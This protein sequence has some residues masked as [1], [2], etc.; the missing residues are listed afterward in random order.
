MYQMLDLTGNSTKFRACFIKLKTVRCID[1][2]CNMFSGWNYFVE[3]HI[4]MF[5]TRQTRGSYTSMK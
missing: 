2:L 5:E 1:M 3:T 4:N